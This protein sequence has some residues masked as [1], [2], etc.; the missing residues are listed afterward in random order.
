M[1]V[2]S[3]ATTKSPSSVF[4]SC[5]IAKDFNSCLNVLPFKNFCNWGGTPRQCREKANLPP[6]PPPAAPPATLPPATTCPVFNI[7][8]GQPCYFFNEA[9]GMKV[10]HTTCCMAGLV[11]QSAPTGFVSTGGSISKLCT[12]S[13]SA[14]PP[15]AS[16]ATCD[17]VEREGW[18]S[19]KYWPAAGVCGGSTTSSGQCFGLHDHAGAAATCT[20]AGA[21]LCTAKELAADVVGGTGCGY[22]NRYAWSS[23]PC[24]KGYIIRVGRHDSVF[25][26]LCVSAS[27]ASANTYEVYTRC[28]SDYAAGGGGVVVPAAEAPTP[29]PQNAGRTPSAT[30]PPPAVCEDGNANC[31]KYSSIGF[32]ESSSWITYMAANCRKSCGLC[33]GSAA[34]SPAETAPPPFVP[35]PAPSSSKCKIG[36]KRRCDKGK[37]CCVTGTVCQQTGKFSKCRVPMPTSGKYPDGHYC[38]KNSYCQS[39]Y[40]D[41]KQLGGNE[42]FTCW[43]K[44]KNQNK[45]NQKKNKAQASV[46]EQAPLQDAVEEEEEDWPAVMGVSMALVGI[47]VVLVVAIVYSRNTRYRFLAYSEPPQSATDGYTADGFTES[48]ASASSYVYEQNPLSATDNGSQRMVGENGNTFDKMSDLAAGV[49]VCVTEDPAVPAEDVAVARGGSRLTARRSTQRNSNYHENV[50]S[51]PAGNTLAAPVAN[52][53]VIHSP[54]VI[55]P[56]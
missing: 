37:G 24:A 21:R 43:T 48:S 44:P 42:K 15:A 53:P 29:V 19:W 56:V 38:E 10:D 26:E 3:P 17:T 32:C 47:L 4:T 14:S 45:K 16:A 2:I 40:C 46:A 12:S 13:S 1:E 27:R 28:C 33:S 51:G 25:E 23:T 52:K 39:R 22:N 54:A 31:G 35:A 36:V 41:K 34:A 5:S 49:D 30:E 7:R 8:E 20:K 18:P 6:P 55:T 9:T 11:C 50:D